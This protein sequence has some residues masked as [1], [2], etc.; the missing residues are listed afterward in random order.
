[1][2]ANRLFVDHAVDQVDAHNAE[3]AH[4]QLVEFLLV[5]EWEHFVV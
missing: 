2:R 1:M 5:D 3:H 4:A